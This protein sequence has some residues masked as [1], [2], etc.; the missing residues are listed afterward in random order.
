MALTVQQLETVRRY[1]A[2]QG[3]VT[4]T[5]P[6][7]NAAAVACDTWILANR[8]SFGNTFTAADLTLAQ[9][10]AV[11]NAI[12]A[13]GGVFDNARKADLFNV[14]ASFHR[15]IIPPTPEPFENAQL[16]TAIR[17]HFVSLFDSTITSFYPQATQK[18]KIDAIRFALGL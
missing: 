11:S 3:T 9:R 16:I 15:I 7:I 5:E 6:Q 2:T 10:Q 13:T 8:N 17:Q 1:Y 14:V 12:N 18:Q 4:Q